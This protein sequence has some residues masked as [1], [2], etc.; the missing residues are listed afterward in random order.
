MALAMLEVA[1]QIRYEVKSNQGVLSGSAVGSSS[2]VG[3]AVSAS[4]LEASGNHM[5]PR[6]S[7][8][9]HNSG[10]A[11]GSRMNSS[12][13]HRQKTGSVVRTVLQSR[14]QRIRVKIGIHSGRVISGV[15]G[16]KKPQ[17]ALF[18]DTVNT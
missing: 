12:R 16:A 4:N 3:P 10:V 11:M 9:G 14:P 1:A 18:G 15:V 8:H 5:E 2:A 7:L 13:F 6:L 17:Y